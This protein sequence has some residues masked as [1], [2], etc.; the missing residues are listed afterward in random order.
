MNLHLLMTALMDDKGPWL[1]KER[2][3]MYYTFISPEEN[4]FSQRQVIWGHKP[5]VIGLFAEQKLMK[6]LKLPFI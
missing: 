2:E 1:E 4:S 5:L 3:K 6:N